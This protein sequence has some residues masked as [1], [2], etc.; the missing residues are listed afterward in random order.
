VS[1]TQEATPE[2][3]N[4]FTSDEAISLPG[5][6]TIGGTSVVVIGYSDP[7]K[8]VSSVSDG[9]NTYTQVL[10]V[11]SAAGDFDI[12]CA[13]VGSAQQTITVTLS[14]SSTGNDALMAYE[15]SGV[16][17]DACTTSPPTASATPAGA[18]STPTSD[19]VTTNAHA[20]LVGGQQCGNGAYTI[21]TDF[22]A[23]HDNNIGLI[24]YDIVAATGTYNMSNTWTG[25]E[26][27]AIGLAAL[28]GAAAAAAAPSSLL[29][30]G[31]GGA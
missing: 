16:E 4:L 31:I 1:L 22:V 9:A 2:A 21:D 19:L 7:N 23:T 20:V 17:S 27:C 29:L 8:T 3:G 12:W 25:T 24:G 10:H 18:A 11:D 13:P 30:M 5:T 26:T 6:M 14:A 15:F 28:E